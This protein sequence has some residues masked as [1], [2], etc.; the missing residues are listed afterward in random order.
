MA[1]RDRQPCGDSAAWTVEQPLQRR[2]RRL[3]ATASNR[4]RA[5]SG[6][7][8]SRRRSLTAIC[9]RIAVAL[10]LVG[11]LDQLA[12]ELLEADRRV[13]HHRLHVGQVLEMRIE[14]D[15]IEDAED[16]LADL[17][18]AAGRPPIICS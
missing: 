7:L 12:H 15:R 6:S 8:F 1:E 17:G 2:L 4:C 11:R 13:D 9:S 5:S 10:G 18:A 16:L 14:V 3:A